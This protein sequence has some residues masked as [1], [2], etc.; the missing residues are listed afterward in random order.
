MATSN[1][2]FLNQ[3]GHDCLPGNRHWFEDAVV[4]AGV[5]DFT[6][7]DLRHTFASR[8][9]MA[10]VSIRRVQ[11]L[12]GHKT[13]NMTARYAH[14]EPAEQLA[15]VEKLVAFDQPRSRRTGGKSRT[16]GV[17]CCKARAAKASLDGGDLIL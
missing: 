15:A 4:E 16:K 7:H 10:G 6:W 5:R 17:A 11:E 9:I 12:M 3:D 8:L 1:R 2:V 14:L 13:I